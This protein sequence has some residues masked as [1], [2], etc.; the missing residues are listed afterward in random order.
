MIEAAKYLTITRATL[1]KFVKGGEIPSYKLGTRRIFDKKDLDK[2][3]NALRKYGQII[4]PVQKGKWL[5]MDPIKTAEDISFEGISW[6]TSKNHVFPEKQTLF[7][8]DDKGIKEYSYFPKK[9]LFGLRMC[10]LNSF[11][12]ND[13]QAT[14]IYLNLL[15]ILK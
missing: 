14:G 2:L 9:V 13:V 12:V 3:L 11:S 5:R 8:F 7:S 1:H 15:L 4:G 10:D 6:Y